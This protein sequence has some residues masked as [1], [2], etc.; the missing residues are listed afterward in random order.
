MAYTGA[1]RDAHATGNTRTSR[2]IYFF[3]FLFFIFVI[4]LTKSFL[5]R[6]SVLTLLNAPSRREKRAV[7]VRRLVLLNAEKKCARRAA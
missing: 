3:I 7:E 6:R 1:N 2:S 4:F 5:R